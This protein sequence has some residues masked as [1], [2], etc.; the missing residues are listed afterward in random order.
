MLNAR[1][2]LRA[3][4]CEPAPERG[5]D[6]PAMVVRGAAGEGIFGC[7]FGKPSA[8]SPQ[9]THG[10]DFPDRSPPERFSVRAPRKGRG[11]RGGSRG[12]TSPGERIPR[13]DPRANLRSSSSAG[14]PPCL[15]T[16]WCVRDFRPSPV[17]RAAEKPPD[18]REQGLF[19]FGSPEAPRSGS[20]RAPGPASMASTRR[21]VAER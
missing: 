10:R 13:I 12:L 15:S 16:S 8:T 17:R 2:G 3:A 20:T 1:A 9:P 11:Q 7:Y 6:K 5:A 19:R 18:F 21:D 14:I 4:R